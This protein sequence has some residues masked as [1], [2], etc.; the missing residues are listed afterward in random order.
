MG[1]L[2]FPLP[3]ANREKE[4]ELQLCVNHLHFYPF[5]ICLITLL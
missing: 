2:T 5:R 3:K 1:Q 4:K